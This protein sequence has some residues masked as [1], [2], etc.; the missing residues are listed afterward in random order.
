MISGQPHL[1][2]N[3]IL[4]YTFYM[5]NNKGTTTKTMMFAS[6]IWWQPAIIIAHGLTIKGLRL[7][8]FTFSPGSLLLGMYMIITLSATAQQ[9]QHAKDSISR[10]VGRINRA[11][12][13][14]RPYF[15]QVDRVGN[16]GYKTSFKGQKIEEGDVAETFRTKTYMTFPSYKKGKFIVY[17]T[18]THVY[19]KLSLRHT[20][21]LVSDHPQFRAQRNV[22]THDLTLSINA[23]YKDSLW[24]RPLIVTSAFMLNSRNF[25]TVEK[26]TGRIAAILVLKA[27]QNTV[28][29][30]GAVASIDPT[31]NLPF[32]PLFSYWHR[33]HNQWQLDFVLPNRVYL[34]HTLRA[35]WISAGTELS[36]VHG[37]DTPDQSI[38]SGRYEL[39]QLLLQSGLNVEYP[40]SK[41]LLLGVRGGYEVLIAARTVKLY[42]RQK[43]HVSAS[44]IT[45][46]PFIS[47]S[48]AFVPGQRQSSEKGK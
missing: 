12:P 35:G 37:F 32:T 9:R 22:E 24:N 41:S 7:R 6:S 28:I 46:G 47:F 1:R 43:N 44:K 42:G 11:Y 33:F 34:R 26:V 17:P 20:E 3:D 13:S 21:P 29:T 25:K 48:L 18:F 19:Q 14:I 36:S 8:G 15:I 40:V 31:S 27:N 16:R 5:N 30:A 23:V 38:L 4:T 10:M 2:S 45:P 39:T